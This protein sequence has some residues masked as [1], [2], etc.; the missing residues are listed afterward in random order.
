MRRRKWCAFSVSTH[1]PEP[2]EHDGTEGLAHPLWDG[3][4]E[5]GD[6][7]YAT[8]VPVPEPYA[9]VGERSWRSSRR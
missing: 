2:A 6:F 4:E 9:S 1:A 8:S 5:E 7:P 3:I